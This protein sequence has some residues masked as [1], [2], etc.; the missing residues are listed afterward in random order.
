MVRFVAIVSGL[1]PD[2]L[3]N[4]NGEKLGRQL[5]VTKQAITHQAVRFEDAWHVKFA[6]G[7][8]AEGRRHMAAARRGGPN[9]NIKR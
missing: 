8:S 7:R 6:R 5:G 4:M 1:R 3:K 9:Q 2:L